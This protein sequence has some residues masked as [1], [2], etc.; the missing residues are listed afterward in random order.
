MRGAER[1]GE[2]QGATL[3]ILWRVPERSARHARRGV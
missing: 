2:L 1:G 3:I